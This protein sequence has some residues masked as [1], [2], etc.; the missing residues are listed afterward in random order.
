MTAIAP[1]AVP[2]SEECVEYTCP[3]HPEVVQIGPGTCP[4]C[5]MA[6]EPRQVR[7]TEDDD[8]E[9]TDMRRRFVVTSAL[10]I[11]L[12]AIAMS[13][14]LPGMPL[15][16]AVSPVWLGWAQLVLASPAVLWGGWPFFARGWRSITNRSPNMFT[17]VALGTGTAFLYSVFATLVP[18]VFPASVRADGGVVPVYFEAAAVIT[19]LVQLGQVLELRARSR[20]G[21]A[22]RSL[23]GLA[24][25]TARRVTSAGDIDVGLEEV[26]AGDRLRVR[27]G[28]RVPVDGKCIEGASNVD[29]SMIT[30]EP[31]PVAKAAGDP[32]VGGTMNGTG[33]M[34]MEAERVGSDTLLARIVHMVS[35][36]QRSRAPIQ[37]VADAVAR[38]FVPAVVL[39][40]IA[41]FAVWSSVGPEPRFA[42]ALLAAVSVVVIACPCA[43]GLATP[44]SIMV[45]TGR[46]ATAG[47]LFKD[48]QALEVLSKVDVVVLDKTGTLTEGKP[49]VVGVEVEPG[50]AEDD[51]IALAA[52]LEALSEHPLAQAIVAD[53][54]ARRVSTAAVVD[55]SS[56]TGKGV[57]GV[58]GGKRVALG[59][60]SLFDELGMSTTSLTAR[61]DVRRTR[62]ETVIFV[63]IDGKPAGLIAIA[64]P[65][66]ATTREA[67]LALRAQKLEVVMLTGDS[68]STAEA[69]AKLLGIER[70][71]AEVLP[72]QK[73]AVVRRLQEQGHTVAMAGDGINDAPALAR[74]DVGIAMGTGTDVAM[75]SAQVTLVKGDLRGIVKARR[76]SESTMRNIRQNLFFA[77][78]Y[79]ALGVPVAAGVLFPIFGVL[80]SPMLASLA[81]TLSSVSVIANALRLRRS[82]L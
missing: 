16:H 68:R 28:E 69:V 43:L 59:N 29:E 64:D 7:A 79:N 40:A 78:V 19:A 10:A 81:M 32:L 27:P 2:R 6:L 56:R 73:E 26:K 25:K 47:V 38:W 13:D 8:P 58:V 34:V 61:A 54:R 20:T 53:A 80:L 71:D 42:H 55:F 23:L 82:P 37:H 52:S 21:A 41:S 57:T 39:C 70:V 65:V 17:L 11:P 18:S 12:L 60:V 74:A 67:I 4:K 14:L 24:P 5:G 62:A 76:L 48:A 75:E 1:A 63:A 15:Q 31:G 45:G 51:L 72:D 50:Q 22:I 66:K 49:R 46:G 30:G 33:A 36:A 44:M 9:L 3:M 77:F 35:E